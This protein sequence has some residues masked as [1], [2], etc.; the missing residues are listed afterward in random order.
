MYT[1]AG[2]LC[3]CTLLIAWVSR[4]REGGFGEGAK[5]VQLHCIAFERGRSG[6]TMARVSVSVNQWRRWLPHVVSR[7]T[8]HHHPAVLTPSWVPPLWV[9]DHC[10]RLTFVCCSS[11]CWGGTVSGCHLTTLTTVFS[12]YCD[13]LT[14]LRNMVS[15]K[16]NLQLKRLVLES[17]QVDLTVVDVRSLWKCDSAGACHG[18]S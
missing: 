3:V 1:Q 11:C 18:L 6:S 9:T 14:S 15:L 2:R 10:H 13:N 7:L 16:S 17:L 12:L 5:T 8:E 4:G